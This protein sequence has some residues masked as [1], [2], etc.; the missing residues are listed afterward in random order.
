[1]GPPT[2]PWRPGRGPAAHVM[3]LMCSHFCGMVAAMSELSPSRPDL[4]PLHALLHAATMRRMDH[5]RRI[6]LARG[7]AAPAA[8]EDMR[9]VLLARHPAL[10]M[11]LMDHAVAALGKGARP[12]PPRHRVVR[13]LAQ[14]LG[15]RRVL[16]ENDP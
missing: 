11:P 3:F 5:V 12:E 10:P 7:D 2:G 4:P 16:A 15:L 9:A 6:A 1:L 13:R 8:A 14:R